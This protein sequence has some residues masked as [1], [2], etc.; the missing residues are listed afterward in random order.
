M[1]TD[2]PADV[3]KFGT[4]ARVTTGESY[5]KIGVVR[6]VAPLVYPSLS[7]WPDPGGTAQTTLVSVTHWVELHD[8]EEICTV[9][10]MPAAPKLK[11]ESV[12]V[13][14]AVVAAFEADDRVM[15][16]VSKLNRDPALP[17]R[18]DNT[19]LTARLLVVPTGEAQ[20]K[21]VADTQEVVTQTLLPTRAV[22]EKFAEL[23]LR[24][25]MLITAPEVDGALG[26]CALV[27]T[28]RS[29]VK[30][31]ALHPTCPEFV[32]VTSFEP[33]PSLGMGYHCE[34]AQVTA[35][36]DDQLVLPQIVLPILAVAL[37]SSSAKLVP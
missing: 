22:G 6:P 12:S 26:R 9:P 20:V 7:C 13:E 31:P 28:G 10:E 24:P 2:P 21:D 15:T 3:G 33:I 16:A 19:T 14:P 8:D 18:S 17:T 32:S 5:V 11:P 37:R 34:S 25:E 36:A 1:V 30:P 35:V 4:N 29:Y 27:I 23:K